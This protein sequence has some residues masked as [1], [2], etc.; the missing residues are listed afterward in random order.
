MHAT[1]GYDHAESA[2]LLKV[3]LRVRTA[4]LVLRKLAA[5]ISL[6]MQWTPCDIAVLTRVPCLKPGGGHLWALVNC[7]CNWEAGFLVHLEVA[8][9]ALKSRDLGASVRCGCSWKAV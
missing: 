8:V 2:D 4:N 6:T 1:W 3:P 7:A 5:G 9:L